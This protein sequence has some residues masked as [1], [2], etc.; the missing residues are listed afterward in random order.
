VHI[1]VFDI[2]VGV[3]EKIYLDK[4]WPNRGSSIPK[5]FGVLIKHRFNNREIKVV[6]AFEIMKSNR[7]VKDRIVVSYSKK[8]RVLSSR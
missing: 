4:G 2:S 5:A 7:L 8:D 6:S 3:L 1:S